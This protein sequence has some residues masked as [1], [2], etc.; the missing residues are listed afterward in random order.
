MRPLEHARLAWRSIRG[1]K[2]RSALT[3]L[4]VIIGIAAVIAFVTLGASLQA[5]IV[6]DISPDDQRNLYGWAAEPETEG[7]P[8][9]GAQPVVSQDDLEEIEE[10]DEV[11]AAYGYA[12]VPT[13]AVSDGD[14]Q[15]ALGDGLV[16]TGPSYVRE[17][18][19][20]EGG[21]SRR[22]SARPCSTRRLPN[23]SRRTSP[24]ATNW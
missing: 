24:S 6:G 3:T 8:L 2:L 17:G 16:A 15:V 9:A 20:A 22:A 4:G 10:F 12:T 5:G 19:L 11:S 14:E 7:G 21:A 23:S 1:H 13:Q 18:E